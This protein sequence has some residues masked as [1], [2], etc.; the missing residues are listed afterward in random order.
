MAR[1]FRSAGIDFDDLFDWDVI[2]DG[3]TVPN[4]RSNGGL[5][6][7]ALKYGQKRADVG[8][9]QDGV[10]V[11]N[12]WAAKGTAVYKLGLDGMG[13]VSGNSAKTNSSGTTSAT[14]IVYFEADGSWQGRELVAGGGNSGNRQVRAGT[15]ID[16][17]AGAGEYEILFELLSGTAPNGLGRYSLTQQRTCSIAA[18]VTSASANFQER[19]CTV[20]ASLIRNGVT[21]RTGVFSMY[22]SASGWV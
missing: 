4:L 19:S 18:S 10:D 21:V 3:P 6:Y 12:L 11:S 13:L 7:A 2:G 14:C 17:G 1:G 22:S 15:W 8:Y 16:P 9:R 5:R 20:K